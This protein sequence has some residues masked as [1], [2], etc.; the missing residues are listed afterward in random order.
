MKTRKV[1]GGVV[2]PYHV[3]YDPV[4]PT[5]P[6]NPSSRGQKDT[7]ENITIPQLREGNK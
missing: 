1:E 7:C 6:P 3:T 5:L 2:V 4:L